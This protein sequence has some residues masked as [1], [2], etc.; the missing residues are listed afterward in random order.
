MNRTLTAAKGTVRGMHY[1][2]LPHAEV[3]FVSCLRGEVFDVAVDLRHGS[4]TFLQR[5]VEI[6]CANNHKTLVIPEGISH[7]FQTL[8]E[9]CEMPYFHTMAYQPSAERG[10]TAAD[11]RLSICWPM[12]VD[13]QSPKDTAHPLLDP[14]FEGV[15]L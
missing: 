1:Q 2:L 4:P 3:K 6:L 13:G 15:V 5:H 14:F 9:D 10:L 7:G 11:P 8:S 12:P